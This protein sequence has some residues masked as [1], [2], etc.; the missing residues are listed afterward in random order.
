M[1]LIDVFRRILAAE[2][3]PP[4]ARVRLP[5]KRAHFLREVA[6][7]DARGNDHAPYEVGFG[8]DAAGAVREVFCSGGKSGSDMQS[9]IHD[10]CILMSLALQHGATMADIVHSLSELPDE[11]DESKTRPASPFGAIARAAVALET[12]L[13]GGMA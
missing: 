2:Q 5:D 10:G 12:E 8:P 9:L 11:D 6:F 3:T 4:R 7:R 13:A 1:R